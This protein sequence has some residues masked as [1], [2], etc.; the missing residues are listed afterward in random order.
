M[1]SPFSDEQGAEEGTVFEDDPFG[2]IKKEA[3]SIAPPPQ[4]VKWFHTRDDVDSSQQAH[5]HTIG[6]KH[7]QASAG[8]HTHDGK[9]SRKIGDGLGLTVTGT[10]A[11]DKVNSVI[12]M[13]KNV[14][15]FTDNST[16]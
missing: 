3:G 16:P 10:T 6:I 13:L 14:I 2:A 1:S 7:D 8:D 12:A 5:H 4:T 9:A 15:E 11:N